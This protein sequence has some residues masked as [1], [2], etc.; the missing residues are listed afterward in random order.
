[1]VKNILLDG[2]SQ[3]PTRTVL[4]FLGKFSPEIGAIFTRRQRDLDNNAKERIDLSS[5]NIAFRAV[6]ASHLLSL[7]PARPN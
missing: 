7:P 5:I 4:Y 2:Q 3:Y 1:M 6:A